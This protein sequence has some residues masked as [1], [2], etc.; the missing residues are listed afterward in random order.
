MQSL[1]CISLSTFPLLLPSL[2]RHS[3]FPVPHFPVMLCALCSNV[4][5][6]ALA[7]IEGYKNHSSCADLFP[8]SRQGC[9]SWTL[10]SNA[11]W[12]FYGGDIAAQCDIGTLGTQIISR[13]L[14]QEPGSFHSIRYGQEARWEY[15]K[16]Q[17]IGTKIPFLWCFLSIAAKEG[18]FVS[19]KLNSH[20]LL[21]EDPAAS[22]L[23]LRVLH[24]RPVGERLAL[25][26]KWLGNC[27]QGHE[28]CSSQVPEN[29]HAPTRVLDIRPAD[30]SQQ[31][32][33]LISDARV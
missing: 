9:E 6:D 11:Q 32:Y 3:S 31:P 26:S 8:S 10:I 29:V 19:P 28:R 1:V 4:D 22:Y 17:P 23:K 21:E 30:G 13:V 14:Y 2:L 18:L 5:L 7:T 12:I 33:L 20:C 16:A 25:A 27:L 15:L 24:Q